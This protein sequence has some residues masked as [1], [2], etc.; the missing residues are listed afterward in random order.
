MQSISRKMQEGH[1]KQSL[2]KQRLLQLGLD[3]ELAHQLVQ[4]ITEDLSMFEAWD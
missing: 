3:S 4:P 1:A 2:L